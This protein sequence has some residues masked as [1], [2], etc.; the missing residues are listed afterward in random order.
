MT[1][2]DPS[3]I[4]LLV[5]GGLLLSAA[6]LGRA[7]AA[8]GALVAE[9]LGAMFASLRALAVVCLL[10]AGVVLVAFSGSGDAVESGQAVGMVLLVA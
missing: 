1:E 10:I 2:L 8:I 6:A 3:L 4:L 9:L 5:L 7:V